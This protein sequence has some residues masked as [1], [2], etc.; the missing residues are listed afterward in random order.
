MSLLYEVRR[1]ARPAALPLLAA[2]A[3][4]YFGYHAEQGDRGILTWL[5]LKQE[6]AAAG[7]ELEAERAA[8]LALARRV[9]LLKPEGLDRDM[10][11]ERARVVLGL[12]HADEVVFLNE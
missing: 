8:R 11:D 3:I 7:A 12:A 9:A 2:L 10:L 1:R 6:I 4:G 5:Q